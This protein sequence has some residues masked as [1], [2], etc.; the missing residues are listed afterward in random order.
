MK[1]TAPAV[2]VFHP[3][4]ANR[5]RDVRSVLRRLRPPVTLVAPHAVAASAATDWP[6]LNLADLAQFEFTRM[7]A[8]GGPTALSPAVAELLAAA[9]G[10][11]DFVPSPPDAPWPVNL[12]RFVASAWYVGGVADAPPDR[13]LAQLHAAGAAF[14]D[15]GWG[16]PRGPSPGPV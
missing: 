9:R 10:V 16:P 11:I 15:N 12:R 1:P 6:D 5:L 14:I 4:P 8:P 3:G 7:H 2:L 13:L